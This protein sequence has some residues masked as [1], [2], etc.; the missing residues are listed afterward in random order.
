MKLINTITYD[1]T[2]QTIKY[3]IFEYLHT[4][5]SDF[6]FLNDYDI[7]NTDYYFL[8]SGEKNVSPTFEKLFNVVFSFDSDVNSRKEKVLTNIAKIITNRYVD[9]WKKIYDAY[10]NTQ[11][12][13]LENYSMIE[14]EKSNSKDATN[15]D[16]ETINNGTSDNNAF[17]FNTTS[18]DG[19]KYGKTINDNTQ[20]LKGSKDNNYI[21]KTYDKTLTRSGNIGVTT[22]QQMLESEL[23]LRRY[24]F[25]QQVFKDVDS[26]LASYV[27]G[28]ECCEK[29]YVGSSVVKDY[30]NDIK[31]LEENVTKN[32]TDINLLK[33]KDED[34]NEEFENINISINDLEKD[35]VRFE[36]MN[37]LL[38][39]MYNFNDR[40]AIP[41]SQ[42]L[43]FDA[44]LLR[45][46]LSLDTSTIVARYDSFDFMLHINNIIVSNNVI[47]SVMGYLY[48]PQIKDIISVNID[49]NAATATF[50]VG[51][52][53]S[54]GGTSESILQLDSVGMDLYTL[55]TS[56][57][58]QIDRDATTQEKTF[59]DDFMARLSNGEKL[60]GFICNLQTIYAYFQFMTTDGSSI[61][62]KT[63]RLGT[64]YNYEYTIF[65]NKQY[66]TQ[67]LTIFK[68]L[69]FPQSSGGSSV[70]KITRTATFSYNTEDQMGVLTSSEDLTSLN[71]CDMIK[72]FINLESENTTVSFYF[73]C[74]QLVPDAGVVYIGMFLTESGIDEKIGVIF[75]P[76]ISSMRIGNIVSTIPNGTIITFTGYKF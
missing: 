64:N 20:S 41:T 16:L 22:S 27:Y 8:N 36:P 30:S 26:V 38:Y 5:N 32:A 31:T 6:V 50:I 43:N 69:I 55:L 3:G 44:R 54:S 11:Y 60:S 4:L 49:I 40:D 58:N 33:E 37:I 63:N 75:T 15:T 19:V 61:T 21:D 53:G 18:Q 56:D 13:P 52:G 65:Y 45:N 74:T 25:T 72:C 73:N 71:D 7:L 2:N 35:V 47:L 14:S 9:N 66:E 29:S 68:Q 57:T 51:D 34:F 24:D 10:F 39:Q 70:T 48:N 28:N 1:E 42:N 67:E 17:G 62:F 59:F 12:K 46:V 23:N 76:E